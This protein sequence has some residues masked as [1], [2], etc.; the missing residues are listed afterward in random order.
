MPN[1]EETSRRQFVIALAVSAI[2]FS[3]GRLPVCAGCPIICGLRF[4]VLLG[5][6]ECQGRQRTRTLQFAETNHP[7]AGIFLT[8]S[9]RSWS[10]VRSPST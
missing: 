8:G 7:S 3:G 1:H 6:A 5:R 2:V 10:G 9:P 4:L